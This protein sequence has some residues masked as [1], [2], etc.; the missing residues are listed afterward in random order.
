MV[1][2]AT[3]KK[4]MAGQNGAQSFAPA[5]RVEKLRNAFLDLKLSASIDRARIETRVLKETEGEPVISRRAKV[6]AATTREMPIYIVPDQLIVGS[7]GAKPLCYSVVPGM[8]V[9]M[10]KATQSYI[11]GYREDL[12]FT[13]PS[14]EEQKELEELYPYPVRIA[15]VEREDPIRAQTPLALRHQALSLLSHRHP[16]LRTKESTQIRVIPSMILLIRIIRQIVVLKPID[17]PVVVHVHPKQI[18]RPITTVSQKRLLIVR[19]QVSPNRVVVLV[20]VRDEV[21]VL[22]Q[23]GKHHRIS[24]PLL[25]SLPVGESIPIVVVVHELVQILILVLV[26]A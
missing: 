25:P 24:L 7:T 3:K 2:T 15:P 14:E 8:T 26:S 17:P 9:A 4:Q 20:E 23:T 13:E 18:L 10:R 21:S 11:M 6:F 12:V 16:C 1:K 5:P 19:K 22:I